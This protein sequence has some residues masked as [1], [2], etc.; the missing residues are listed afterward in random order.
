MPTFASTDLLPSVA[1]LV[2]LVTGLVLMLADAF[3][4][5]R[6][7]PWLAGLG[8]L[9]SCAAAVPGWLQ[10]PEPTLHYSGMIWF[11]GV[12][13]LIH[14]FLCASAF[15]SLFFIDDF[16]RRH[17]KDLG[18]V[19]ALLLFA[20][21]GMVMLANGNDLI[22]VFIGL[23]IMSVCLYI[24]A[25]TFKRDLRS[26]EAGMKYFLLGAFSTGFLLYGIALIYGISATTRLNELGA[27]AG[28]LAE[29]PLYLPAF[30]LILVGFLFKIAAF[31][32]HSWTP[33]VYTGAPTPLAGFMATGSKMAAF[34]SLGFLLSRFALNEKVLAL[35]SLLALASMLYGNIVAARQTNIKRMLAYSSIAHTGYLLLGLCAGAVGYRAVVF[36]MLVYTLMTLGAFG[37]VAIVEDQDSDA[38]LDNWRGLGTRR[39][40]VGVAMSAF[41]F[42]LAGVPPLAGFMGKYV[43]FN[44]AV[45]SGLIW[46]TVVG[47]LTSVIGAYYYLRVIVYMYFFA[48]QGADVH[49][50]GHGHGH[51]AHAPHGHEPVSP[52]AVAMPHGLQRGPVFGALLLVVALLVLGM[53]PSLV[54]QT[55]GGLFQ[56]PTVTAAPTALK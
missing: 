14:I 48:P 3:H 1:L 29:S 4:L 23:E 40:W 49:V 34:I 7:L 54:D 43:V 47:V 20:T 52:V 11:G 44:A 46:L 30:G 50:P 26:N 25:G 37:V 41:L 12:T 6:A 18:D 5:R 32:F 42:S 15:F 36:Y 17:H 22:T 10:G 51:H 55:L 39:P 27:A 31:P 38:E 35:L 8:L 19:Y 56:G 16:F 21:I 9:I 53:F 45:Q 33:D 28:V 24:M 2:L 13:G